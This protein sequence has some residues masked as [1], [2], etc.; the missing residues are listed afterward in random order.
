MKA[1]AAG[2]AGLSVALVVVAWSVA[3]WLGWTWIVALESFVV[4]NGVMALSFGI[5]GG[6]LAWQRPA[7]PIGWLFVGG[8]LLQAVAASAPPVG[9]ALQQAGASDSTMRLLATLFV[10]SWPWAIGLCIP[11]ALLL[12]PDGR[13]GV[14]GLVA[15]DRPG[16]HHRAAFRAGDGRAAVAGRGRR[17]G[18]VPHRRCVRPPRPALVHRRAAHHRGV[19]G[20]PARVGDPLPPRHRD[21][22]S[23]AALVAGRHGRWSSPRTWPGA[24]SPAPR[25]RCCSPSR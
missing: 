21:G 17:A 24:W 14:A 2:L 13:S 6:I 5:C 3:V 18:R 22:A 1:L 12:F 15:G 25:S 9:D 20:S 11:L 23:S 19:P 16:A 8:G 7:N 4:T 10:Y